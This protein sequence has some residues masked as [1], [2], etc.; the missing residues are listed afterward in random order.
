MSCVYSVRFDGMCEE[1]PECVF[2][3]WDQFGFYRGPSF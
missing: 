2:L 1:F 3:V